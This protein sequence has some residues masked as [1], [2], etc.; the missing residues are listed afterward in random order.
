MDKVLVQQHQHFS[1]LII[2]D[3]VTPSELRRCVDCRMI[4]KNIVYLVMAAMLAL[5][6]D[7]AKACLYT[8][9][10]CTRTADCC[11]DI[12][13]DGACFGATTALS[14][15]MQLAARADNG[16]ILGLINI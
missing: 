16:N 14:A 13:L 6:L 9:E 15:C 5:H 11:S 2:N 8:G 1:M 12:C 7:L 3:L 10:R 4:S